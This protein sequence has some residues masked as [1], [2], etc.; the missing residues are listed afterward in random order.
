MQNTKLIQKI[1]SN[2]SRLIQGSFKKL[3]EERKP[4]T[5]IAVPVLPSGS[6]ASNCNPKLKS[7]KTLNMLTACSRLYFAKT[8]SGV[9]PLQFKEKIFR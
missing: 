3:N 2:V 6:T 8:I 5:L 1:R 9:R 4:D 7:V